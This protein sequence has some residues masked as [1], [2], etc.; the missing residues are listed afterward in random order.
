MNDVFGNPI[1]TQM[2]LQVYRDGDTVF[3]R[4]TKLMD[5]PLFY[6]CCNNQNPVEI[7]YFKQKVENVLFNHGVTSIDYV[8]LVDC[9][10]DPICPYCSTVLELHTF[11]SLV[12]ETFICKKC[13]RKFKKGGNSE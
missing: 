12:S 2:S 3:V 7:N 10:D 8:E 5:Y 6:H 1:I 9:P 4:P 11:G 13:N